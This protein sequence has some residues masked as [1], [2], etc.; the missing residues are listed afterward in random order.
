MPAASSKKGVGLMAML[1]LKNIRKS[2][3]TYAKPGFFHRPGAKKVMS[4]LDVLNGVD[5]TVNKGDV[6]A[7]LG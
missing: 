1:E 4:T 6:V 7:I 5:L 3:R 2:F